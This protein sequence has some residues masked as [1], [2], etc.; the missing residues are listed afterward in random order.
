MQPHYNGLPANVPQ[1]VTDVIE[2]VI[3]RYNGDVTA[4]SPASGSSTSEITN[5]SPASSYQDYSTQSNVS[6]QQYHS[7]TASSP[8]QNLQGFQNQNMT[9]NHPSSVNTTP[10]PAMHTLTRNNR[11]GVGYYE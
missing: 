10:L 2:D 9:G 4:D 8:S 11:I 3:Q 5:Q 7:P 6:Q 1:S